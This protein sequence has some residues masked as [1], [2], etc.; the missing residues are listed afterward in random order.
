MCRSDLVSSKERLPVFLSLWGYT[1][2]SGLLNYSEDLVVIG[3]PGVS[4][5]LLSGRGVTRTLASCSLGIG[6]GYSVKAP[7][8][9]DTVVA[10]KRSPRPCEIGDVYAEDYG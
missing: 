3:R 9:S 7:T 6:I 4:G 10:W 5:E 2:T 8:F 1:W